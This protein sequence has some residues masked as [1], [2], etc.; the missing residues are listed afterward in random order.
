MNPVVRLLYKKTIRLVKEYSFYIDPQY[1]TEL[2]YLLPSLN[3]IKLN[4]IKS[5]T[6]Q[7]LTSK[8]KPLPPIKINHSDPS[9][10]LLQLNSNISVIG[11]PPPI[12]TRA[13]LLDS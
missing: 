8:Q 9:Y 12:L 5:S 10:Q 13:F 4:E 3:A 2:L 7:H 11:N 1:H 6:L